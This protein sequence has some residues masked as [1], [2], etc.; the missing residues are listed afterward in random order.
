MGFL[1]FLFSIWSHQD[2]PPTREG[3][4]KQ[5]LTTHTRKKIHKRRISK[6]G[7]YEKLSFFGMDTV[8]KQFFVCFGLLFGFL[9]FTLSFASSCPTPFCPLQLRQTSCF[10]IRKLLL[11][12][13]KRQTIVWPFGCWGMKVLLVGVNNANEMCVVW[14]S[15]LAVAQRNELLWDG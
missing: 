12:E 5:H 11:K 7:V 13:K 1:P 3:K 8:K 9:R 4:E 14:L 15:P 6:G 10:I 2:F